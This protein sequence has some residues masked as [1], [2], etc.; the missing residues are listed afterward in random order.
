M[1]ISIHAPRVGSDT[2]RRTGDSAS[3]DFNPRSP[4]GERLQIMC[5]LTLSLEDF[6]PRSPCGE[7]LD[8]S[9]G[10]S[11]EQY[12]NPRSPCGER[13]PGGPKGPPP[14]HFNP[15]SPCGE[16]HRS[17]IALWEPGY[18]NPRSP[19]GERRGDRADEEDKTKYFNPRSPCGERRSPP[20]N[21]RGSQHI[22]IH[23]PRVGSDTEFK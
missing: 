1:D 8:Q 17:Y 12:F 13:P 15:R 11:V 14:A 23:A 19:C 2:A 4:C 21:R 18:F 5:V 10:S 9:G 20:R 7:R 3:A 6:N 16:R 22:S